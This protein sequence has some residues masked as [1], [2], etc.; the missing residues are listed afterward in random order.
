ME[1][2]E[3]KEMTANTENYTPAM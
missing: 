2:I 3:S 1:L